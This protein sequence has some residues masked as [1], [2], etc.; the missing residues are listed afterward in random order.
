MGWAVFGNNNIMHVP[1]IAHGVRIAE[2]S[3]RKQ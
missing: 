3:N 2:M 1:L